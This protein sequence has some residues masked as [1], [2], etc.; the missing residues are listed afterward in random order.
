MNFF[1]IK[2]GHKNSL[3]AHIWPSTQRARYGPHGRWGSG[4]FLALAVSYLDPVVILFILYVCLFQIK[5]G[6]LCTSTIYRHFEQ[7][8]KPGFS[9]IAI[10]SDSAMAGVE[11]LI[12]PKAFKAKE[13][14]A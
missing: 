3:E 7:G 5:P 8:L 4:V 1:S 12:T 14:V 13:K 9:S 6:I 10:S 11:A 2:P